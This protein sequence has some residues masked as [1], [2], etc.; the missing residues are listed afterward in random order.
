MSSGDIGVR[1]EAQGNAKIVAPEGDIDLTA[2]PALR[3]VIKRVLADGGG[4]SCM[5]IDLS[6]VQ[7]MD[8]SGVA[9]LVDAMRSARKEGVKLWLA[10]LGPQVRSIFEIARLD[11]VFAIAPTVEEAIGADA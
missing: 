7:Y 2:S 10:A 1:T 11:Q 9:T 4:I 8:S 6:G 5:V 3:E